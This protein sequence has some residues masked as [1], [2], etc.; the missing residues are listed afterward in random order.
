MQDRKQ[1][2]QQAAEAYVEA[3]K[4]QEDVVGIIVAGS[5]IYSE[6]DK[7]SDIDIYVILHPDCNY[8]ERGNTWINDVEI[9][10]FKNPPQQIRSY[11]QKE[12]NSPHSADM[13]ANGKVVYNIST[14]VDQLRIEAQEIINTPPA[15][16]KGFEI[17]LGKYFLDDLSKDL[18]D[19]RL[20][21]DLLAMELLKHQIV[22]KCIDLF[23]EIHR[24]RRTKH[25]R[26]EQQ[27]GNIDQKFVQL[28][29]RTTDHHWEERGAIEALLA[30]MGTLLGGSRS[31]EW[32]LKSPLDL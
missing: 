7:N 28:L 14:E 21:G 31:K 20:K 27:L 26:L 3:E 16:I 12:Q 10:Y 17:E 24:I 4:Q 13:I 32:V 18:E 1:Q 11:F 8:R 19:S 22:N 30:A 6:L 5:L 15:P 25:K 2:F 23:C 29:K 9:E